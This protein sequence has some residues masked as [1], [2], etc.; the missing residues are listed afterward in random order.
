MTLEEFNIQS[1]AAIKQQL[2]QCCGST[3]WVEEMLKR[4]PYT[5]LLSLQENADAAWNITEEEDWK[6]AFTHHPAIGDMHSL[7]E[8]FASTHHLAS[9]EQSSMAY[10]EDAVLAELKNL[11]EEYY[12][13]FGYIF[14]ICATGKSPA[15]MLNALKKR[16]SGSAQGEIRIAAEEQRKIM[17]LRIVKLFS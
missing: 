10:A 14:I 13:K 2:L 15:E 11:N 16:I 4:I 3:A 1:A 5:S 17:H 7:K 8:K 12:R 6:E 9:A